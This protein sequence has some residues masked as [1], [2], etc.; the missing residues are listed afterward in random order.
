MWR[1]GLE[2]WCLF[3]PLNKCL[4][5]DG[6]RA[7]QSDGLWSETV[8]ESASASASDK[9]MAAAETV[10]YWVGEGQLS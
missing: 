8:P 5:I 10:W 6:K 2:K 3:R 7:K 4:C 1:R 9:Q